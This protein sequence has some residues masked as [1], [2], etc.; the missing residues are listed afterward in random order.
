LGRGDAFDRISLTTPANKSAEAASFADLGLPEGAA[1]FSTAEEQTLLGGVQRGIVSSD[2]LRAKLQIVL[3]ERRSYDPAATL[4]ALQT[5]APE[6]TL[7]LDTV[8]HDPNAVATQTIAWLN[9]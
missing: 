5:H 2:D 7:Y 3:E 1:I 4:A 8:T 9:L 6:R